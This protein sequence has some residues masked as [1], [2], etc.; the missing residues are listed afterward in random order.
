ML[1]FRGFLL[2][3]VRVV[4]FR[5]L[6]AKLFSCALALLL[7]LPLKTL[8]LCRPFR[9]RHDVRIVLKKL[10]FLRVRVKRHSELIRVLHIRKNN[11]VRRYC[12]HK[13]TNL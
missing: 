1:S 10:S 6:V 13:N 5:I 12:C 2:L 4:V 7:D 8:V 9:E 3:H 11:P